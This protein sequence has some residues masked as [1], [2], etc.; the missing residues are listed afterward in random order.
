MSSLIIFLCLLSIF[1]LSLATHHFEDLRKQKYYPA[2]N[3]DNSIPYEPNN[4]LPPG[5][6]PYVRY[7]PVE[8]DIPEQNTKHQA[9]RNLQP[10]PHYVRPKSWREFNG[11]ISEQQTRIYCT[12]REHEE[13]EIDCAA[14][15][16]LI[17]TGYLIIDATEEAKLGSNKATKSTIFNAYLPDPRPKFR[18]PAV[19]HKGECAVFVRHFPHSREN[20]W[21]K[22]SKTVPMVQMST[23]FSAAAFMYHTV[24]PNSRRLAESIQEECGN[25]GGR[26]ETT[27]FPES[28]K[29][30]KKLRYQIIVGRESELRYLGADFNSA[31]FYG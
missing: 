28:N 31:N 15:I 20:P 17:P 29:E 7:R 18:L 8:Q 27:S 16:N 24:W 22:Y 25:R 21:P 26:T 3:Y 13:K 4:F 10:E 11:D 23:G 1:Q 6:N 30:F 19:F 2:T 9:Y 14:A 12:P 5:P